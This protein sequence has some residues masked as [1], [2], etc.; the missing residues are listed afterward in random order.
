MPS[1][2]LEQ[3]LEEAE[4]SAASFR[5]RMRLGLRAACCNLTSLGLAEI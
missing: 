3:R 1:P 2:R 4:K 5:L